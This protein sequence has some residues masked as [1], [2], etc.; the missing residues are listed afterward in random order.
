[1][2]AIRTRLLATTAALTLSGTAYAADMAVKAPPPIAP[3]APIVNWTGFYVGAQIGGASF[4]PS[5]NTVAVP[6]EFPFAAQPCTPQEET[7]FSSS[8]LSTASVIGGGRVGYDWQ[9]DKVV[10][11]VV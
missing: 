7:V 5:C 6:N 8:S 2:N 10:L 4:D 1:M 9:W 11:G 3:V